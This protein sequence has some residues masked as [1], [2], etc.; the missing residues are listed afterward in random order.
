MGGSWERTEGIYASSCSSQPL[1]PAIS[2][3]LGL[4]LF[5]GSQTRKQDE[6]PAPGANRRLSI[7]PPIFNVD[8]DE[9]VV[10]GNGILSWVHNPPSLNQ[11]LQGR[12]PDDTHGRHVLYAHGGEK[13]SSLI[14]WRQYC[15]LDA[16]SSVAPPAF[17]L[18]GLAVNGTDTAG[19]LE[20]S[21]SKADGETRRS[22]YNFKVRWGEAK[23]SSRMSK[24]C[25]SGNTSASDSTKSRISLGQRSVSNS[26]DSFKDGAPA[27]E[28]ATPSSLNTSNYLDGAEARV[29]RPLSRQFEESPTSSSL[30]LDSSPSDCPRNFSQQSSSRSDSRDFSDF[31]RVVSGSKTQVL[32]SWTSHFPKASKR[33]RLK[34]SAGSLAL[35]SPTNFFFGSN[36]THQQHSIANNPSLGVGELQQPRVN[37]KSQS[38]SSLHQRSLSLPTTAFEPRKCILEHPSKS[39]I[40]KRRY[41]LI[42]KRAVSL[43]SD[44]SARRAQRD[45]PSSVY[46]LPE[47]A[48][49]RRAIS[50]SLPHSIQG[51]AI[52]DATDY[53]PQAPAPGPAVESE[54]L[55]FQ[56][57]HSQ[58]LP[59]LAAPA[60][61]NNDSIKYLPNAPNFF[62]S[63][64][65]QGHQR[66]DPNM[67]NPH[68]ATRSTMDQASSFDTGAM[69]THHPQR[70]N[71]QAVHGNASMLSPMLQTSFQS[72]RPL[73]QPP[74]TMIP[75]KEFFTLAEVEDLRI[76]LEQE[77]YIHYRNDMMRFSSHQAAKH[78]QYVQNCNSHL[79]QKDALNRELTRDFESLKQKEVVLS[80]RLRLHENNEM[81]HYLDHMQVAHA[82][83]QRHIQDLNQRT[84]QLERTNERL[85]S[86]LQCLTTK[87]RPDAIIA[88]DILNRSKLHEASRVSPNS[89][90]SESP[91]TTTRSQP[92]TQED[93]APMLQP[94]SLLPS[95]TNSISRGA[96]AANLTNE[97]P[98]PKAVADINGF[99]NVSPSTS[100]AYM[101]QCEKQAGHTPHPHSGLI[102]TNDP[103][104]H[105]VNAV[106]LPETIDLTDDALVQ[107]DSVMQEKIINTESL[108]NRTSEDAQSYAKF[109]KDFCKKDLYWLDG[110]HPGRI[111]DPGVNFGPPSSKNHPLLRPS[112]A[113]TTSLGP[114]KCIS[115]ATASVNPEQKTESRARQT[116]DNG[117]HNK[118]KRVNRITAT[119]SRS[120]PPTTAKTAADG[121]QGRNLA[122]RQKCVARTRGQESLDQDRRQDGQKF[123]SQ[124]PEQ[125]CGDGGD[126]DCNSDTVMGSS[127]IVHTNEGVKDGLDDDAFAKFIEQELT[128]ER[129]SE[130]SNGK[131]EPAK[132]G[133]DEPAIGDIDSLFEDDE[134]PEDIKSRESEESEESEEE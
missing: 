98:D 15:S 111:G 114:N 107:S 23:P 109:T 113:R 11:P 123:A 118:R 99:L 122:K 63:T 121:K 52:M 21:S 70:F 84:L 75:Q 50:L 37:S 26:V 53:R 51:T 71:N 60:A 129:E 92:S 48:N 34:R 64:A 126:M 103:V 128:F 25:S 45:S 58:Q 132:S 83:M 100:N 124:L 12:I 43:P 116:F 77:H 41:G 69:I 74:R 44:S 85:R 59:E 96:A 80:Q 10:L 32:R 81:R 89:L 33:F 22:Q 106:P 86:E 104:N 39:L 66:W 42:Y 105:T 115:G 102:S 29:K 57:W 91:V 8:R 49:R 40:E 68:C 131:A 120:T 119:H 101:P 5:P 79:G 47:H 7:S 87:P 27:S 93:S 30:P 78:D 90:V 94:S 19:N 62:E 88:N 117:S 65:V 2:D 4:T 56:D 134:H 6:V 82:N 14:D 1:C 95:A 133:V 18:N 127:D 35:S 130:G 110:T 54:T 55:N 97:Y 16:D 72:W 108:A 13:R 46:S 67:V 73:Q 20:V 61:T 9:R 28:F 112:M 125:S 76:R 3:D 17:V 38:P 24:V 31:S 36:P